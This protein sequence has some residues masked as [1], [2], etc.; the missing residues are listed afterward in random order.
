MIQWRVTLWLRR[1]GKKK[2]VTTVVR[3]IVKTTSPMRAI[4]IATNRVRATLIAPGELE[5]IEL[6]KG[7]A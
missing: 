2:S 4:K 3:K 1:R 5:R 7:H 6:T